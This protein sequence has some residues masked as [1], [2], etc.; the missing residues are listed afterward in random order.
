M[1]SLVD[2]LGLPE[3]S[4]KLVGTVS[5]HGAKTALCGLPPNGL[6]NTDLPAESN[7]LAAL[8]IVRC[9]RRYSLFIVHL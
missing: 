1:N 9:L 6:K 7:G 3:Q 5:A 4:C 2:D 8:L